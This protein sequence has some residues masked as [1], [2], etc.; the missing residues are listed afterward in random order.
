MGPKDFMDKVD[1]ERTTPEI[2][3]AK[4]IYQILRPR[5]FSE[6]SALNWRQFMT[7]VTELPAKK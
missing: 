7:L 4:E 2:N 5:G 6:I 3:K 1:L